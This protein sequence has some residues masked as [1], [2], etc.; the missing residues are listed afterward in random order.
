VNNS[1]LTLTVYDKKENNILLDA[2]QQDDPT[3]TSAKQYNWNN[4]YEVSV[5][6]NRRN[7]EATQY[8]RSVFF[9][10]WLP[11][12]GLITGDANTK[13]TRSLAGNCETAKEFTQPIVGSKIALTSGA[14][15]YVGTLAYTP[16]QVPDESV[17]AIRVVAIEEGRSG[18]HINKFNTEDLTITAS[19]VVVGKTV[20]IKQSDMNIVDGPN[21][22]Y[23]NY[24]Y[25]KNLGIYPA[26]TGSGMFTSA[27]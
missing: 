22:A 1:T 15:G 5:W 8:T 10:N 16:E 11:I 24:L 26:L 17:Y 3:D 25:N 27:V 13:G 18:T 14:S 2:L 9:K 23:V 6:A 4:I 12:P 20:T 19:M 21:Y 7:I